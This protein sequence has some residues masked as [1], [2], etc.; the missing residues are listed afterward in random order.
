MPFFLAG[1]A[2][3][4]MATYFVSDSTSTLVKW[5]VIGAGAYVAAKHF[6]VL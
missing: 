5:G 6:K 2:V 4:A 1:A 3:G